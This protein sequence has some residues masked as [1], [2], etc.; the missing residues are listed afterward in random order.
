M[1]IEVMVGAVIL[2]TAT[3][4]ILGGLDGARHTA[5]ANKQRSVSATLAQQDIERLRAYPITALS[6]FTQLRS[7]NVYGVNFSVQSDTEWVRDTSGTLNC[8]DDTAQADYLKISSTVRS[9]GQTTPVK[10]VSLLTPAAGSFSATAGTLVVKVTD[11]DSKPLAG[12]SVALSGTGSYSDTTNSEGCAIFGYIPAGDY[13]VD[14]PGRV[15]WGGDNSLTS[16]ATVAAAKTSLKQLEVDLPA[17]LRAHLMKPDG[18]A[19][20]W[21]DIQVAN[22]KLPGGI[23]D[24]PTATAVTSIDA[25]GLFPFLDGYG[26]YAGSCAKNNPSFWDSTY[27]S[28]SGKGFVALAPADNL[29]DVNV[30]M[31]LVT[32]NVKNSANAVVSGAKVVLRQADNGTGCNLDLL[33]VPNNLVTD[34]AGNASAVLPFGT[35]SVCASGTSGGNTRFRLSGVSGQPAHPRIIPAVLSPAINLTLPSSGSTGNCS[36]VTDTSP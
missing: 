30:Q 7:V 19:A 32:V 16:Q 36:T 29:K 33:M 4:A 17:S 34:A 28:T 2:A 25:T 18:T 24:F 21:T 27:F 26:V 12:V 10:E 11:R 20:T 14:V 22:A 31:G 5:Q 3:F 6:N 1:L 35:Y 23:R 13:D 8:T 9:P 15:S